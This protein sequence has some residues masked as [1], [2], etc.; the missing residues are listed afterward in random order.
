[1]KQ[2]IKKVKQISMLLLVIS[3]IGCENDDVLLPEVISGFTYT[4]NA[5]T[6][7][8]TFINT[9]VNS[10]YYFWTFGDETS[11]TEINPIKTYTETESYIV[12]LKATNV[13]GASN[14]FQDTINILIKEAMSLP[15][16]FDDVAVKYDPAVFNGAAFEIVDNPDVSGTN[17]KASKVGAITNSGGAYEGLNFDLGAPI[18]FTADKTITMNF[19]ADGAVDV[20][21]KLEEGTGPNIEVNASHG[22]TGWEMISFDFNSSDK[23][24]RLTLFVDGP[25]T[26]AGTFYID[27]IVQ[28]K[29]APVITLN[30]DDPMSVEI[31]S[32]FTD[33]GATAVDGYNVDISSS[34]VIGGDNVDTNTVGTYIITYNVSDAAGNAA[35]EVTRTVIVTADAVAPVITLIGDATINIMVGDTFTDPGATATDNVDGD[36]T[37]NIVVAGDAVD[38]NTAGTYTISY[39]VSDA[40]GNAAAE[41]T[42]TVTVEAIPGVEGDY[43]YATSGTVTIPS[44]IA[45]WGTGTTIDPGYS[46]DEIGRASCRERV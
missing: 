29:S 32:T 36:I 33:P 10:N 23:Y 26:T 8:V 7:T 20:L 42:R 5:D 28:V 21:M 3:F 40:A 11:A 4:I 38:V 37:A 30:G 18:D 24:S 35:A 39:N 2:L 45:D 43:I 6:G 34:I 13:S 22:G 46:G 41:V 9:S 15:I 27:D 19:W 12:S 16:T 31:G 25:G 44:T 1:M 14:I 17:N